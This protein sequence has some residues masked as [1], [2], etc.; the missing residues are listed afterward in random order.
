MLEKANSKADCRR[1]PLR[2][3]PENRR[4]L[5]SV[6][7]VLPAGAG[8]ALRRMHRWGVW[9]VVLSCATAGM[10]A[11]SP[12]R[13]QAI[14]REYPLKAVYL[15]KFATYVEWPERA[16]HDDASPFVIGILGPDPL[17]ADL[18]KIAQVKKIDGRE[19]EVRNYGQA[20]E[21]RDCHILFMSSAL[22]GETQQAALQLLSG[23]N[24]LFVGETPDFLKHTGVIDFVIQD[25]RIRIFISKSAYQREGLDISAQLLRI[26]TVLR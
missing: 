2:L 8:A 9:L 17:G 24:I 16:F 21:I 22:E 19:I 1:T 11:V 10:G 14:D 26:A 18:R 5:L 13:G 7:A 20:A 23:R 6:R 4:T 3:S 12:A 15:Y 25:N